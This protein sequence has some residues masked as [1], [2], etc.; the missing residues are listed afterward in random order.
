MNN[1]SNKTNSFNLYFES[2]SDAKLTTDYLS[3]IKADCKTTTT[4][5]FLTNK[6]LVE[7]KTKL[8]ENQFRNLYNI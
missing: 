8:T 3:N 7:V 1:I 4:K 2:K 5:L 6:C